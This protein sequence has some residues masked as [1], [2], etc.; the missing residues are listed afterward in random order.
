METK[1]PMSDTA[2]LEEPPR[3]RGLMLPI[4]LGLVL[5]AAAGGG[6]YWAVVFGPFAP[7]RPIPQDVEAAPPEPTEARIETAFVPLETVIVTLGPEETGRHLIFTAEL[8]VDPAYQS[9]VARLSPRVLDVLNSYLRVVS[10]AELSDPTSL[11]RLRAQMLR[12]V[13]VV[14]GAGRVRDLLITQFVVN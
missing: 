12:R 14:T 3:K 9:E 10:L 2:D 5:A 6:G 4:L 1:A 11:G 8:E 7:P 13:Q